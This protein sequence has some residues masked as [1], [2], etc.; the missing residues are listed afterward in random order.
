M[1]DARGYSLEKCVFEA[2]LACDLR[3]RHCGSAAG[4]PRPDELTTAECAD[5]FAQLADLGCRKLVISGGEPMLRPDWVELAAAG[6]RTGMAV[7]MITNALHFDDAAAARARDAG[8]R[9]VGFSVDG[10][11]TTHD[12]VRAR[13]G[14]LARTL[15]AMEAATRAH[16][17][18]SVVTHVNSLNMPELR[19]IHDLVLAQGAF[20]WQVQPGGDMGSMRGNPDLMLKPRDMVRI[21]RDVATLMR[22][23]R[24][25]IAVADSIGYFGPEEQT[26]R[27]FLGLDA[28]NGCQAGITVVGIESNGDVKGCLSILP[29]CGNGGEAFVEGNVR[30]RRLADIWRDP[31]A[32]SY[33]RRFE[34]ADLGGFCASCEHA[35]RCRGGCRSKMVASGGG[36]E[37]P[38]CVHRVLATQ[39]REASASVPGR[40]AAAM[41]ASLLGGAAQGCGHVGPADAATDPDAAG[42]GGMDAGNGTDLDA[43]TNTDTNTDTDTDTATS[44]GEDHD[45]SVT[46]Y[47]MCL[48]GALKK[49]IPVTTN[50]TGPN[51]ILVKLEERLRMETT[52]PDWKG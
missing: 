13:P 18:F 37:N 31:Y 9:A 15:E 42:T 21:A 3:C 47:E 48:R 35:A 11:G 41:L 5:V 16:L 46:V 6:A 14:L 17:P 30:S 43:G 1:T 44:T 34:P 23:R 39:R 26:L 10:V 27:S 40:A 19:A 45:G 29:G 20:A 52:P 12:R 33:N 49:A 28:F 50:C 22:E 25:E 36:V 32:F 4:E 38:Y 51:C 8:L 2:T 7:G 24:L